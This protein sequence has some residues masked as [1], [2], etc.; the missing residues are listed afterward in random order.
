[1]LCKA[2]VGLGSIINHP[3]TFI[4]NV[5]MGPLPGNHIKEIALQVGKAQYLV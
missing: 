5:V 4:F 2:M 1:M 3:P